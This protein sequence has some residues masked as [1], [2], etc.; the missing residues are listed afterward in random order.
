MKFEKKKGDENRDV[1]FFQ[2]NR[3]WGPRVPDREE[4]ENAAAEKLRHRPSAPSLRSPPLEPATIRAATVFRGPPKRRRSYCCPPAPPPASGRRPLGFRRRKPAADPL[5]LD[6]PPSTISE[7]PDRSRRPAR[8]PPAGRFGSRLAATVRCRPP[9][10]RL[11]LRPASPPDHAFFSDRAY[12]G[13]H[14]QI[15]PIGS[16][17]GA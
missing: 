3:T 11:E 10:L 9:P 16:V 13:S 5:G 15:E 14:G 4:R 1:T 8:C 7:P 12:P 6:D 17:P 2:G